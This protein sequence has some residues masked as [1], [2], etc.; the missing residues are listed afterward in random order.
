MM[1]GLVIWKVKDNRSGDIYSV[2]HQDTFDNYSVSKEE[3]KG[4]E[5][6]K[7]EDDSR[8]YREITEVVGKVRKT[9]DKDYNHKAFYELSH[10]YGD[11]S[12]KVSPETARRTDEAIVGNY[13][14][15]ECNRI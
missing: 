15:L 4:K 1:L 7:V 6:T 10:T 3:G 12:G 5:S 9:W 11:G 2:Y 13:T 8:L 14:V